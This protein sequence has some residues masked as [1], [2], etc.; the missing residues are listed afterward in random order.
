MV[1]FFG[2]YAAMHAAVDAGAIGQIAVQRFTR[3]GSAPAAG[4]FH[5]DAL[6]G[7]LLL[8]QSLHDLDFARWNAGEVATAYA[9][10]SAAGGV[11]S[12]QV[13]LT[14]VGGALSLVHGTWA[15]PGT[16]VPDDLRHRRHRRGAAARLRRAPGTEH[17]PRRAARSR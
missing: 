10:E 12:V 17:R 14:H 4:W 15:R 16:P 9:L 11:R 5:D 1:R 2:E 7:G 13:V 8:D 3:T 6:S